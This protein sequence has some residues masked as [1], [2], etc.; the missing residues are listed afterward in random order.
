MGLTNHAQEI[1]NRLTD[2]VDLCRRLGLDGKTKRQAGGVII[3]CP[4]HSEKDPSCSVTRGP[5]GTVRARCFSCGWC[6]DALSIIAAAA[7]LSAAGADFQEVLAR[8]AEVSGDLYLAGQLRGDSP[9]PEAKPRPAAPTPQRKPEPEYPTIREL[10]GFVGNLGSVA[11]DPGV[12]AMLV[13]RRLD[14]EEVHGRRLAR[15]LISDDGKCPG[16]ASY[17]GQPWLRS[18]HRLIVGAY[19]H[20]GALRSVR[21]WLVTDADTPKR[22]PPAGCKAAGLVQANARAIEMLKGAE[23]P[24]RLVIVE[25]EPDFL[26]WSTKTTAAVIGVGSGSW[27]E[28]FARRVPSGTEVNI[29]THC[30]PAGEKYATH[31]AE[32]IGNRAPVWRLTA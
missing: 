13:R 30:D 19:D 20:N 9:S 2:P 27:T 16:W 15:A 25:G 4:V 17:R 12:C 5:D 7:G 18:G 8:G 31:I 6:G 28:A 23:K 26:T 14:P 24:E 21:A 10:N 29:R 32:T 1:R 3:C 11:D 22:L